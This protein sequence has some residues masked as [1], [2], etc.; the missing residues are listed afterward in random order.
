MKKLFVAGIAAAVF[1][2]APALAADLPVK[3]PAY[4]AAPTPMFTWTGFYAGLNGGYGWGHTGFQQADFVDANTRGWFLG[5]QFGYNKQFTNNFVAGVQL[6]LD[7]SRIKGQ[8]NDGDEIYQGQIKYF[9]TA[10]VRAGFTQNQTFIYGTGGVAWG[11][12][13]VRA[14][15]DPMFFTASETHT[16][17]VG[18]V[19]GEHYFTPTDSFALEYLYINLGTKNYD[20][21]GPYGIQPIHVR[22]NSVRLGWNHHY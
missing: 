11:K 14:G 16:G 6:D 1:C 12:N 19:G 21:G 22:Y 3:A 5:G 17:W 2:G 9:G 15:I 13:S 10:R 8:V 18:G 20:I 4:A 7:W